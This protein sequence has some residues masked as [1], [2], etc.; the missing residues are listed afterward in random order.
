MP[1]EEPTVAIDGVELLH[2]PPGAA[3]AR[4][5]EVPTIVLRVPVIAGGAAVTVVMW[6]A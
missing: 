2:V 5:V 6:Y 4:V 3:S 1:V